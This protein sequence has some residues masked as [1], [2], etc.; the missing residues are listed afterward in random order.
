MALLRF[1]N[2][3]DI[4]AYG[5][6]DFEVRAADIVLRAE[7]VQKVYAAY[8]ENHRRFH[9]NIP[10]QWQR[11]VEAQRVAELHAFLKDACEA[12]RDV[13]LDGHDYIWS[14]SSELMFNRRFV[15]I[16][17]PNCDKVFRPDDC[18]VLEWSFGQDLAASGGRRVACPANHTLYS[19]GEW[20]S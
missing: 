20:N 17:C 11:Y 3:T 5:D 16:T 6:W 14:F 19:C 10:K 9:S 7:D 2:P 1:T 13:E 8:L 4:P 18:R 12:N 15:S